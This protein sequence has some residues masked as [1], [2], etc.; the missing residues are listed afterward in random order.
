M[1]KVGPNRNSDHDRLDKFKAELIA[2]KVDIYSIVKL[3]LNH[4][5]VEFIS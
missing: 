4:K 3:N 2:R 1:Q 5:K